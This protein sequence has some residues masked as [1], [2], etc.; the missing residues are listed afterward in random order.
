MILPFSLK[1]LHVVVVC[2]KMQLFSKAGLFTTLETV[3]AALS[4]GGVT[5]GVQRFFGWLCKVGLGISEA[6]NAHFPY[7]NLLMHIFIAKGEM[8]TRLVGTF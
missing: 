3:E 7:S 2:C 6:K 1:K 5:V 4:F 8:K